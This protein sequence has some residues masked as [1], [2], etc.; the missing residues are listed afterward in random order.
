ML[1]KP[2]VRGEIRS[3]RR[4]D[5]IVPAIIQDKGASIACMVEDLSISGCR[6]RLGSFISLSRTFLFE[7]PRKDIKVLAELVWI[8]GDEAGIRFLH[9]AS[10]ID[11]PPAFK[12]E[13]PDDA[14][15]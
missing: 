8:N 1:K 15:G 11:N 2:T 7:F 12:P 6:V 13:T 3:T 9:A 14:A 4:V 5:C 10:G